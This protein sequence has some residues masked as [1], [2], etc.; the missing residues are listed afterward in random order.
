[1]HNA[2]NSADDFESRYYTTVSKEIC[3][4]LREGG[5]GYPVHIDFEVVEAWYPKNF[6]EKIDQI[7]LYL[8]KH[9]LHIGQSTYFAM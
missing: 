1:M 3:D 5:R 6:A 4:L 7:L 9:A 8:R 2:Y